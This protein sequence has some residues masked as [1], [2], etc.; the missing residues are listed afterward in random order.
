VDVDFA[1]ALPASAPSTVAAALASAGKLELGAPPDLDAHDYWYRTRLPDPLPAG[2]LALVLEGLA[3]L[4]EVFLDGVLLLRSESM[5]V[6]H[7]VHL[8]GNARPGAELVLC[9]RALAPHL[10]IKRPRPRWRTRLVDQQQLRWVRTT[11]LGRTPGFCPRVPPVGPYRPVHLVAS[12]DVH[13]KNAHVASQVQGE[14]GLV[15]AR[16]VVSAANDG[17][18]PEAATLVVAGDAGEG[19]GDLRV[20]H[21]DGEAQVEGSVA[22]ER[23]KRWWPHT[24]G[25]QPLSSVRV[26][27]EGGPA[28][29]LGRVGF[30]DVVVDRDADGR[31]FG[32]VINGVPVFCRGACWT[33]DDVLGLGGRTLD[34]TLDLVRAAGMNMLRVGGT[35]AYE[36]DAFYDR[37][38]ELGVLVFQDFMFANMDYPIGDGAFRAQVEAEARTL[39]GRLG[40][41]PSLAVL[42]GGSEVEQQVSMLG[43]PRE[44]WQSPLFTELLPTLSAELA[45]GVPYV[46]S[47]PTGGDLPFQTDESI[48]HYYGV[49]AYLRSF[50]DAR[51]SRVRFAAECLAFA[52]VP[53]GAAIERFMGDLDMP[54]H[55]PR[56]KERVPRDRGVGWDFEDVRDHYVREL[57]G[58]DP[59]SVRHADPE[60]YLALSRVAPGL[61]M[62]AT[63]SEFRRPGSSCRGALVFWLQDL[64]DGAGWGVLDASKAP[65]SVYYF[66]SRVFRPVALLCTDEGLNGVFL[67][68]IN[69]T[70]TQVDASVSVTLY[71]LGETVIARGERA[72]ALPPRSATTLR[73]ESLLERFAD[74]SYAYRFGPP[75]HDLLVGKLT[76]SGRV[77]ARVF[78][79]PGRL[80]VA[81]DPHL[82]LSAAV[83]S[84]SGVMG[85]E[86]ATNRFAAAISIDVPGYLPDDDFFHL[87]PGGREFIPLR[88]RGDA[89]PVRGT[90]RALN[91]PSSV[92]LR[93]VT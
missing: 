7:T 88:P 69:E 8:A 51:R 44:L 36:N 42:C 25:A 59:A 4:A 55:H 64:W 77:V 58:V 1:G 82:G 28:I 65:K 34:A 3:T 39:L 12:R 6:E 78:F 87:E 14:R 92:P 27:L 93:A 23:M 20:V 73:A 75:G 60:R 70:T 74:T 67:H 83:E 49:G 43:M 72:L 47:S 62:E 38:D 85:L 54:F 80:S 63:I 90:V 32:L 18:L 45:P 31:G 35:T 79:V 50:D 48:T 61:A 17:G 24:H 56:W 29:E 71:R 76:V 16:L 68:A 53:G 19:R 13:V 33:T 91:S 26:E 10:A 21:R 81:A 22:I 2:D 37:C 41:R 57:F 86:I 66:L 52:N 84:R 9:F 5:F 30:R 11:L 46:T 15:V 89:I 40:G